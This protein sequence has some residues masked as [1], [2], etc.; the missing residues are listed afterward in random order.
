MAGHGTEECVLQMSL[1]TP[2]LAQTGPCNMF[3]LSGSLVLR[4][5]MAAVGAGTEALEA[6]QELVR[7]FD[8]DRSRLYLQTAE[9]VRTGQQHQLW[10]AAITYGSYL[11]R[12]PSTT[13]VTHKKVQQEQTYFAYAERGGPASA[14]TLP[15]GRHAQH[16]ALAASI[17]Q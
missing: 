7:N 15:G 11:H 12:L 2:T 3:F 9:L 6:T 14:A 8:A 13:P 1:P 16:H 10:V 4:T 5:H 17:P